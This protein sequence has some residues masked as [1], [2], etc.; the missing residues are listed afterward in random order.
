MICLALVSFCLFI[1]L[2]FWQLKRAE[3]KRDTLMKYNSLSSQSSLVRVDK[4]RLPENFQPIQLKGVYL[5]FVLYLDN[6]F[7]HH[8]IGYDVLTPFLLQDGNIVLIDRGWIQALSTRDTLPKIQTPSDLLTV[9]GYVYYPPRKSWF[10]GQLFERKNSSLAV[11]E[12]IDPKLIS[13]F[14]HKSAYPF[15]IRLN[16]NDAH[17]FVREWPITNFSP[18]RHIG[19][20]IQWFGFALVTI[21]LF[22]ALNLKKYNEKV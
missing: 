5:P 17:G 15:I 3:E 16:Q 21:L 8:N 2:G 6:Q 9:R 1:S 20:A 7:Y 4:G 13:Q 11:I 19:Y 14:L 10:L 12:Y 18:E 22:L